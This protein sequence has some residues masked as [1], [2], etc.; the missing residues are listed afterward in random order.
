MSAPSPKPRA[1]ASSRHWPTS[2]LLA[3][4]QA[5]GTVAQALP[6]RARRGCCDRR[7]ATYAWHMLHVFENDDAAYEH[8]L[9]EHP[10]GYVQFPKD[11]NIVVS[12]APFGDVQPHHEA[13]TRLLAMDVGR[14]HHGLRRPAGGDRAMDC[15]AHRR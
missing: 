13:S 6:P 14:V 7:S 15:D 2:T 5:V 3:E 4:E 12:Q 10:D 11:P 8:W 9:E 1:T